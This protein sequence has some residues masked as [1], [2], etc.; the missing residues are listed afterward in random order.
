[1]FGS[2]PKLIAAYHVFLR[3]SAPRHPPVA[4]IILLILVSVFFPIQLSMSMSRQTHSTHTSAGHNRKKNLAITLVLV[5]FKD[6]YA[7]AYYPH[8]SVVE[9][10]GF[11]PMTPC[12]QGRCSPS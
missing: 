11:E 5:H 2:S 4:L 3:L 12:V 7:T 8:H 6:Q 1:M 9:A 10:N